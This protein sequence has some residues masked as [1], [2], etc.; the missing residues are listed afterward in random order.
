MKR[1]LWR[2]Q[3]GTAL[4]LAIAFIALAVPIVTAA[5]GLASAL[6]SDSRVKTGILKSQYCVMG[7]DQYALYRLAYEVGY[8]VGLVIGV[9]ST[10]TV[11]LDSQECTVTVMKLSEPNMSP[12]PPPA[13]NSRRF[14]TTKT[15]LPTTALPGV[16]TTFTYTILAENRDDQE[17][18]L[19]KIHDSLPPGFSYVPGSTLL[20]DPDSGP[21]TSDPSVAGQELTWNLS[22]LGIR[23]QPGESRTLVFRAQASV[24][25]GN[26]CNEAWVEPGGKKTA[27]P[28]TPAVVVVVGSPSTNLCEGPATKLTK[29]VTPAVQ[30]ANSP[31]TFTYTITI[32]SLGTAVLHL[33]LLR[34]LL[35]A[36]FLYAPA[37]TSGDMTSADPATTLFQG[38]QRLDWAFSP[39]Y[40]VQ[41]GE[42]RTLTFQ[43][44]ATL[45]S[46]DYYNDVWATFDEISDAVY[47]WPTALVQVMGV[48]Q[49][50]ATDGRSTV[51]SEVWIGDS[52]YAIAQW[53]ISR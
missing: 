53:N 51:S 50:E 47:S 2:G 22:S 11:A 24:G 19:Q 13:D 45:V 35:P 16:L 8:A 18:N 33:S 40:E 39:T 36:G 46:G 26:Y 6:S 49:T 32:E 10:S 23:L 37:S 25:A 3:Q 7:A 1:H 52:S 28:K 4:P 15:V 29:A 14:Q 12:P 21:Y 5:L 17:E 31:T 20:V 44:Q 30:S 41:P 43:A 38:R 9:P 34:D 27:S 48:F 42:I